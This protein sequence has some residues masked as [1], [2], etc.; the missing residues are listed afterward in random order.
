V[1]RSSARSKASY[2]V[3]R[4]DNRRGRVNQWDVLDVQRVL[5]MSRPGWILPVSEGVELNEGA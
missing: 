4:C 1:V 2:L 5:A 3:G